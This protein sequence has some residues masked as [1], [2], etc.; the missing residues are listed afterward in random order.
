MER[1]HHKVWPLGRPHDIPAPAHT[2]ND[3][4]FRHAAATPDKAALVFYGRVTTYAQLGDQATRI[5]GW[6]QNRCGV[7]PGDRVG[8][9]LQNSPQWVAAFYGII[10]AGAVAVPINPMNLTDETDYIVE[11]AGIRTLFTAQDRE[12]ELEPLLAQNILDHVIVATYSD[13]L[14]ADPHEN[15]PP[16]IAAPRATLPGHCT[17]WAEMI[18]ANETPAPFTRTPQ[19][20]AVMPYTSGSTG[21]GKGCMHSHQTAIH[22]INS[23]VDW[24][25]LG[26]EDV[27]F[28]VAPMFHVVG[29][30]AGLNSAIQAGGTSVIL[31][32]WDREIAA[33]LIREF[34]VTAWPCVP[35]MII[36]FLNRPTL[37]DDDLATLRVLWGGGIAMPEA[38]AEKLRRL[39]GLTFLEG[40]GMTETIAPTSANPPH[41]PKPQCAGIPVFNTDVAIVDP[42]TLTPM[43]QGETGEI[44]ISGPQVMLAYWNNDEANAESFV[45]LENQRFLRSGDLGYLDENGYIFIVD[46]LKRMINASG[47]K[48]WPT[49]VEAK[50]YH[51]PAIEE[52]CIIASTDPYRGETVKA[53]AVLKPGATL[54]AKELSTWAHDH[55]AAYKVPRLLE[56]V[57][58]LPKSGSGKV[59]WREL[60]E[61][62]NAKSKDTTQ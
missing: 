30:Q 26:G 16:E 51:H 23:M 33:H 56:I 28:C 9:Q 39:T 42:D 52:A 20:L 61:R 54:T 15:L 22:A 2:L 8:I 60:Q 31:P 19:D 1:L 12:R 48:V 11:D 14:P 58:A 10:R 49:E 34:G 47:Y 4:L 24:F 38:V 13:E 25:G 17:A 50:L 45:T 27:F 62:E 29:L 18:A 43:P 46:R 41:L 5:A 6:L 7:Q 36:D 3:N 32:R 40:Y 55:M 59:L 35:T 37:R 44:L 53:V 21:R 57:T